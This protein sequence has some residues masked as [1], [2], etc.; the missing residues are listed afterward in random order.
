MPA[1]RTPRLKF[2]GTSEHSTTQ[3]RPCTGVRNADGTMTNV[4][5][6]RMK[7]STR[8]GPLLARRPA[9]QRGRSKPLPSQLRRLRRELPRPRCARWALPLRSTTRGR[10]VHVLQ[11]PIHGDHA[12]G[13][14]LGGSGG[15]GGSSGDGPPK[16]I[17]T[18]VVPGGRP[19]GRSGLDPPRQQLRLWADEAGTYPRLGQSLKIGP[20]RRPRPS[21]LADP[22]GSAGGKARNQTATPWQPRSGEP[23]PWRW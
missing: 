14:V 18:V 22:K 13:R 4:N 10:R 19:F 8:R 11:R 21:P 20:R 16:V 2:P 5:T 7:P 23:Q 9:R 15:G 3:T 12:E 17:A 6:A 1:P